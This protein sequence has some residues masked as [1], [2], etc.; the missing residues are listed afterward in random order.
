MLGF[1]ERIPASQVVPHL[2]NPSRNPST[3][4]LSST[5]SLLVSGLITQSEIPFNMGVKYNRLSTLH[6]GGY[7]QANLVPAYPQGRW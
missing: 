2:G 1:C 5:L 4:G 7:V 3:K 6:E